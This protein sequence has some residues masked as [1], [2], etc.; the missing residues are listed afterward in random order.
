MGSAGG[1][2]PRAVRQKARQL[3]CEIAKHDC[4]L[5]TGASPGIP[6][7]AVQGCKRSGGMTVGIS[8]ALDL[9][10]HV[11]RYRSPYREFDVL[12]YT[13]DGLMGREV[14]G[15]RSC[16]IVVLVGG[17]SGT[18]GEFAIAYDEGKL[19]GVL[20]ETGGIADQVDEIVRIVNKDTGAALVFD[21][22]PNKL[23]AALLKAYKA[24]LRN[25][26]QRSDDAAA[27]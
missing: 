7:E 16:D 4:I 24:R 26:P 11:T 18:L 1:R 6:Y 19:I 13:G 3:G 17:R 12:I 14:T 9:Q 21:S 10:E 8:P 25:P 2:I 5:L 23:M 20:Q 15:I 22:D 27:G